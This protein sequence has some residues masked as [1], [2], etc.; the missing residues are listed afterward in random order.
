MPTF[1]RFCCIAGFLSCVSAF[2]SVATLG[3]ASGPSF[4]LAGGSPGLT[5][6]LGVGP[7]GPEVQPPDATITGAASA[8]ASPMAWWYRAPATKFWEGMPIATGRF[9][10]MVYGRV[11]DEVIPFNDETLWT[12]SPNNPSNPNALKSL[13]TLRALLAEEKFGEAADL[14]NNF[15]GYPIPVVQTYQAMGRLHL[16]FD[17]HDV[18]QDYRRE[19]DMDSA[20]V[21]VSYRIGDVHYTREMFASYPDQVVV[22]RLTCDRP[23]QLTF[24]T[25]LSSLHESAKGRSLGDDTI[26]IEG[27]VSEPNAEIPSR[28]RWQGRVHVIREGGSVR[29]VDGASGPSVRVEHADS[30]TI[31]LAGATNYKNWHD[32]TADADARCAAY[33]QA[34]AARPFAE[35]K[36]RHLDDYQP[37]FRVCRL[38]LGTTAAAS[39]DTTTRMNKLRAGGVDPHFTAQYFQYGRYL[40]LAGSRAGTM[41]FNNHNI[42]LDDLKGRWRGRWTL[43][44]NLQECYWPAENTNLAATVESLTSFVEDLAASGARSAKEVY[45]ARGWCAHHGTD[46]WMNTAMTDRVFHGMAPQM[47]AWLVQSLWEH[48]LFDPNPAYLRRIYPLLKGAT[49]FGLDML[50]EEP[51]HKWLVTSPSGSPENG[52]LIVDGRAL[53]HGDPKPKAEVRNSISAGAVIDTQIL[54]DLFRQCAEAAAKLGVDEKLRAEIAAALPRLAPTQIRSDGTIL[55]WLKPYKEFDP[56]HRHVSQLYALYPS[57]QITRRDTPALT[58]AARKTLLMRDDPAGW[59]GAWKINLHARLGDAEDAYRVIHRMQTDISKHPSPEDS[60]RVPSMEGNQGIQGFT[61]GVA[62]LLLQSHAGEI[63]IL[64]A[65]PEA[66]ATGSVQGLRARGGVT[67]DLAWRDGQLASAELLPQH[68]GPIRLRTSV[69][70]RIASSEKPVATRV[71]ENGVVEFTAVAGAR[72][73]VT[74]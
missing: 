40:L 29:T 5:E 17:G 46:V 9:A 6:Q 65:L 53:M 12:G 44:I 8:P 27:G 16:R 33:Q 21:R 64:P 45:G 7:L 60:D 31:I 34:V 48:Y 51:S 66:W 3:A 26:L 74:P 54:R 72:Y 69:P 35:L 68:A 59:T 62:E 42:W 23:G 1:S 18:V 38:D 10:A 19:L 4:T 22:V 73:I 43:N 24:N 20:T 71:I 32:L 2:F 70:I 15:L 67:V 28:M 47:G 37:L 56:K 41:A 52:F 55:E 61:A 36:Q 11:R 58:A 63:E 25:A 50:V 13:P 30:A 57:N 14:A 39:D 49:E